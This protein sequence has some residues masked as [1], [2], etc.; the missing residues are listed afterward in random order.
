MQNSDGGGGNLTMAGRVTLRCEGLTTEELTRGVAEHRRVVLNEQLPRG[1]VAAH[2]RDAGGSPFVGV[3]DAGEWTLTSVPL[4]PEQA[5][6]IACDR[7]TSS[8][9]DRAISSS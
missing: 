1:A 7:A 8:A 6:R 5:A 2:S 3:N 9:Q 4:R